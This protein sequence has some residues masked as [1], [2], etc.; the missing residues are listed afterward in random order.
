MGLSGLKRPA[1]WVGLVAIV[2][3]LLAFAPSALGAT[4]VNGGPI[5]GQFPTFVAD[6][7]TVYALKFSVPGSQT[8]GLVA[9]SDYY[10]QLR[11]STTTGN[12]GF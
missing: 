4:A 2:A 1:V 6:D 12:S 3:L 11:F 7:A 9:N 5:A 10:V 8:P